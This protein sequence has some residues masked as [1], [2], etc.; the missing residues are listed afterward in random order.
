MAVVVALQALS[1]G[2]LVRRF[3][4]A[5]V[6]DVTTNLFF[7]KDFT[8]SLSIS[9]KYHVTRFSN[10]RLNPFLDFVITKSLSHVTF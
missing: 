3:A 1:S 8:P 5:A 6:K 9:K 7:A 2:V 10:A 4:D